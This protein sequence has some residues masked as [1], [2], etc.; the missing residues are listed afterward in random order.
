VIDGPNGS[1]YACKISGEGKASLP[2]IHQ[3][4]RKFDKD[5]HATGDTTALLDE[6]VEDA[7]PLMVPY[8]SGGYLL[9]SYPTKEQLREQYAR[10]RA[11]LPKPIIEAGGRYIEGY[12]YPVELTPR[13]AALRDQVMTEITT[14]EIDPYL[15]QLYKFVPK[16]VVEA[17]MKG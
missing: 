8:S 4:W 17:A 10:G 15:A 13:A 12:Q 11:Q 2:G 14:R 6:K 3:V 9:G 16:E 7:V 5:G 1:K